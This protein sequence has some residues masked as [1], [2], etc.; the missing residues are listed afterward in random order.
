MERRRYLRLALTAAAMAASLG[1]LLWST[2]AEGTEYYKHVDEVMASPEEWEGKALQLHGFV[3]PGSIFVK[4]GTLDYR[5]QVQNN[6][7]VVDVTYRGIV[8]DTFT[9]RT[10]VVLRGRLTP[11]GFR[12]DPNGVTTK[13]P[14]RYD[15]SRRAG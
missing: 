13:C 5:F 11:Q 10:E 7:R 14:S 1:G 9:D 15:P 3:V 12:A 6:G 8:P 4:P 2:V